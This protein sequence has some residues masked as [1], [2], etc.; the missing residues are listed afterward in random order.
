[1]AIDDA[2]RVRVTEYFLDL[3]RHRGR[4]SAVRSRCGAAIVRAG[5]RVVSELAVFVET[6]QALALA[7][8]ALTPLSLSGG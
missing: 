3:A 6:Q 4:S 7:A 2:I 5:Q 1:M 8:M